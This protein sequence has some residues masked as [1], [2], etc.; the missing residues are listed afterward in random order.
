MLF[1]LCEGT[2]A[3]GTSPWHIRPLEHSQEKKLGGGIDTGSL[4]GRVQAG[5][6]WDLSVSLHPHVECEHVCR[7]CK[8]R[9]EDFL[10][11]GSLYDEHAGK[12]FVRMS[13]VDGL[14]RQLLEGTARIEWYVLHQPTPDRP[15]YL[16][17]FE[18]I[19]RLN[20][21]SQRWF[22]PEELRISVPMAR[23]SSTFL[24]ALT[25]PPPPVRS[26]TGTRSGARPKRSIPSSSGSRR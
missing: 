19:R 10:R 21:K 8:D 2:H 13:N 11:T 25:I 23:V 20:A 17:E 22:K 18:M 12:K 1:S 26:S 4:C 7:G 6:G 16:V 3:T 24:R 5:H 15:S 9:Y 14:E